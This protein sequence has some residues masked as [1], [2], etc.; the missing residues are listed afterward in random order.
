MKKLGFMLMVF[1]PLTYALKAQDLLIRSNGDTIKARIL[2]VTDEAFRYKKTNNPDGPTFVTKK[3]ELSRVIYANG[4]EEKIT[5]PEHSTGETTTVTPK[6]S[7]PV[8]DVRTN[9]GNKSQET[10]SEFE[11]IRIEPFGYYYKG[12]RMNDRRLLYLYN[13]YNDK[14]LINEYKQAK[15]N[16]TAS[17]VT[18]FLGIPFAVVGVMFCAV[19]GIPEEDYNILTG[20]S[21]ND[22]L[23]GPGIALIAGFVGLE[24]ASIVL[25]STYKS[26]IKKS[27]EHYNNVVAKHGLD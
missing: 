20:G 24:V 26:K 18:G 27:V 3:A 5:A 11:Q 1:L 9:P 23:L 7:E 10:A 15:S 14:S 4:T 16:L 22:E 12:M 13:S 21:G 17:R 2:E 25:H 8:I 6:S 19:S